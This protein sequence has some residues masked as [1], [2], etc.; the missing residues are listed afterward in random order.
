ME[1]LNLFLLQCDKM[2]FGAIYQYGPFLKHDDGMNSIDQINFKCNYTKK[3]DL[4]TCRENTV[5]VLVFLFGTLGR[6]WNKWKEIK[7]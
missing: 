5:I 4:K 7:K 1:A 2:K 6:H 3:M